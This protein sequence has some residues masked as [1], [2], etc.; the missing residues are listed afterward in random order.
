MR[1]GVI[2]DIHG[3]H[4]ALQAV[5]AELD[6]EGLDGL[7]CL[8]DAIQGGAEPG[9]VVEE[10]RSRMIPTIMGNADAWLLSGVE[11]G[12][13]VMSNERR[14]RLMDTREWSLSRLGDEDQNF[15]ASF[16]PTI[17]LE[18]GG[19]P[20]LLCFHGSPGSFDEILMPDTPHDRLK[21]A[22]DVKRAEFFCG[23]HTH[24]QFLRHLGQGFHFNPGSVGVAYRYDQPEGEFHLDP[25]AEYA[26]L[27]AE[28]GR[29][30]LD[31]R[32]APVDVERVL[33][34]SKANGRPYWQNVA[35]EYRLAEG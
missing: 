5:L 24:V 17:T 22:L 33:E 18:M 29:L 2:S 31:F 20:R 19:G 25:F 3:N 7:V 10:L 21:G 12:V 23:G 34:A 15:I 16:Q 1:L 30:S 35:K 11:T 6:R 32:R 27:T 8:G 28:G 13:E 14:Q 26:I 4:V 9:E